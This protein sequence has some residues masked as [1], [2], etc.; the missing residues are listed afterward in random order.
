MARPA[1][2]LGAYLLGRGNAAP[3][4][5]RLGRDRRVAA[6]EDRSNP[7]RCNAPCPSPPGLYSTHRPLWCPLAV[8]VAGTKAKVPSVGLPVHLL[9]GCK[10]LAPMCR[11]GAKKWLAPVR[12]SLACLHQRVAE[13]RRAPLGPTSPEPSS[14]PCH[15]RLRC[16]LVGGQRQRVTR[17][18]L[19]GVF[20]SRGRRAR[21]LKA[22][23]APNSCS[24]EMCQGPNL[25][26]LQGGKG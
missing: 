2:P 1:S 12:L 13:G 5:T 20:T 4:S 6:V 10:P 15:V 22:G 8:E 23:A 11:T 3:Q 16:P 17:S 24:A 21:S 26:D 18:C 19:S 7:A 9:Y 25:L 14:R